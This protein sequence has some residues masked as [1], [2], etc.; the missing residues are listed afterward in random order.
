MALWVASEQMFIAAVNLPE[1]EDRCLGGVVDHADGNDQ[2]V[3]Y[4]IGDGL[5][6]NVVGGA[7]TTPISRVCNLERSTI[8]IE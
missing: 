4:G 2:F 7:D 3:C 6:G 5:Q 1:A 8:E